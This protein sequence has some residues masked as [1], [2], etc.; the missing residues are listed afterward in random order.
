MP[1]A[2]LADI[3]NRSGVQNC[4]RRAV[5]NDAGMTPITT[6]DVPSRKIV[7]PTIA[8]S[9]AKLR[10]QSWSLSTTTSGVPGRSSSAVNTRPRF[11]LRPNTPKYPAVTR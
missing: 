9:A 8:L 10:R 3:V 2:R 4:A 7:F 6:D 11:G 1:A 5:V